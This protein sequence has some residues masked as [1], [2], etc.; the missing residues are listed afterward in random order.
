MI[1]PVLGW[2]SPDWTGPGIVQSSQRGFWT[3]IGPVPNSV[4][5]GLDWTG[6]VWISPALCPGLGYIS[7]C[8]GRLMGEIYLDGTEYTDRTVII[9]P[10]VG[11]Q[12]WVVM[13][14]EDESC[15]QW[16]LTMKQCR[17]SKCVWT[18]PDQARPVQHWQSVVQ[19]SPIVHLDWTGLSPTPDWVRPDWWNHWFPS[20]REI[21]WSV[22]NSYV[23]PVERQ[24]NTS[25]STMQR[26][27]S[28]RSH[29]T[30]WEQHRASETLSTL[31]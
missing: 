31:D 7:H 3:G 9:S 14:S 13:K 18:C 2:T 17:N 1:P 5:T 24:L 21:C 26:T 10:R 4:G 12:R 11:I 16:Y 22:W 8:I 6:L 15:F 27:C 29:P 28:G 19:S 20:S 25:M 23:K 30:K